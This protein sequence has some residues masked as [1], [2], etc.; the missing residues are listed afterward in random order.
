M[1][2]KTLNNVL[3][4]FFGNILNQVINTGLQ[5]LLGGLFGG[6]GGGGGLLGGIFGGLFYEGG[7]VPNYAKGKAPK[8]ISDAMRKEA[9]QSG[10]KPQL[11]VVHEN[12][13]IIP[14]SRAEKLS[15]LGLTPEMLLGKVNNYAD[16]GVVGRAA[17]GVP[18]TSS[19]SQQTINVEYTKIND[20]NY[21]TVD[22]FQQGIKTAIEQ[23][24]SLGEKR[25]QSKM[26]NSVAFRGSVGMR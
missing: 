7:T 13:L 11:A 14:A 12:E 20:V 23:G 10:R 3:D 17:R 26:A 16:G 18:T 8:N 19:S 15:S 1:G 21:V 4:D 25:V 6:G 22:Q 5:S 9:M 24:G 2:T